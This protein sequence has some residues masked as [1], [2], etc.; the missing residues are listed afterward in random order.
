MLHNKASK[1]IL[2]QDR[3]GYDLYSGIADTKGLFLKYCKPFEKRLHWFQT[4]ALF[5]QVMEKLQ[6]LF[7]FRASSL[8]QKRAKRLLPLSK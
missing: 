6:L 7:L 5:L 2:K 4:I 1:G 8:M 3:V